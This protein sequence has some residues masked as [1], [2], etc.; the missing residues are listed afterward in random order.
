MH[1]PTVDLR[2]ALIYNAINSSI[3]SYRGKHDAY[4]S[5]AAGGLTGALFK[6]TGKS[7]L[8]VLMNQCLRELLAAGVR[9]AIATAT[10]M[11]GAAG[12][13]SFMKRKLI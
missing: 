3:D 8:D 2:Q 10:L 7:V 12:I 9:P 13:W 6:S 5:M 1:M 4:G 11:T